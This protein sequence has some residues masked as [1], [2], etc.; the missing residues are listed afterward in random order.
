MRDKKELWLGINTRNTKEECDKYGI[1]VIS[2]SINDKLYIGSTTSSFKKRWWNHSYELRKNKHANGFL[3]NMWNDYEKEAFEFTILEILDNKD[4]IFERE[5]YFIDN[6]NTVYPNGYNILP[7][8]GQW[9]QNKESPLNTYSLGKKYNFIK[10]YLVL[11]DV[12]NDRIR[13]ELRTYSF[14]D[15]DIDVILNNGIMIIMNVYENIFKKDKDIQRMFG[16]CVQNLKKP[17][18]VLYKTRIGRLKSEIKRDVCEYC[19]YYDGT[20]ST[21]GDG[22]DYCNYYE[23]HLPPMDIDYCLKAESVDSMKDVELLKYFKRKSIDDVIE[24]FLRGK[25]FSEV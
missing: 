19:G 21:Y 4:E 11:N 25:D 23:Q 24:D 2:N 13:K 1:Y 3:Q 18:P 22:Y 8:A 10:P 16:Y 5:Q 20:Y 14:S 15:K 7:I 9:I 6:Y 12:A 17:Y